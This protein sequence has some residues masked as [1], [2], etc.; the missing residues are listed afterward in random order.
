MPG[1]VFAPAQTVS[2]SVARAT[3]PFDGAG[4]HATSSS[5]AATATTLEEEDEARSDGRGP[6]MSAARRPPARTGCA[7]RS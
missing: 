7:I 2:A 1:T 6:G 5:A 3:S 4:P